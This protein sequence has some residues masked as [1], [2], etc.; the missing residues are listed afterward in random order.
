EVGRCGR[1]AADHVL[2]RAADVRGDGLEDDAVRNLPADVG[3]V[4]PRT[5][6]ELE[7]R[8]VGV[9]DLDLAGPRVRNCSVASHGSPP[10]WT[11]RDGA[12]STT[13]RWQPRAGRVQP[14]SPT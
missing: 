3:G 12:A 5:V 4:H 11:A 9:D 14:R 1:A 6:L 8:V 7:G 2:V 13:R 10:V